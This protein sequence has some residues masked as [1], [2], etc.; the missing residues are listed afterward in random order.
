MTFSDNDRDG[1]AA[2]VKSKTK[3]GIDFHV[4]GRV[5]ARHVFDLDERGL[6]KADGHELA[7]I[8]HI[9]QITIVRTNCIFTLGEW[10]ELISYIWIF[11]TQAEQDAL[12]GLLFLV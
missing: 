12:F 9:D 11:P 4:D 6:A 7:V 5:F 2:V 10:A 3:T 8:R 1:Y